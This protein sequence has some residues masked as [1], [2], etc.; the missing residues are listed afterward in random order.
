MTSFDFIAN[1]LHQAMPAIYSQQKAAQCVY[2]K[3]LV[4]LLLTSLSMHLE[5]RKVVVL[6]CQTVK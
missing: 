5:I 3:A 2:H 1:I 4:L 6:Y